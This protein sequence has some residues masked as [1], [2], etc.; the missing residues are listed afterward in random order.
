MLSSVFR[1]KSLQFSLPYLAR[2][3]CILAK[4]NPPC[5]ASVPAHPYQLRSAKLNNGTAMRCDCVRFCADLW[6]KT[7][8]NW[9]RKDCA[10]EQIK[11][12]Q[13]VNKSEII[14]NSRT[15][16]PDYIYISISPIYTYV[17]CVY[18]CAVSWAEFQFHLAIC[19]W[20][21]KRIGAGYRPRLMWHPLALNFGIASYITRDSWLIDT[22]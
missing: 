12:K 22:T 5:F 6:P 9:N 2:V 16:I 13:I 7:R 14:S 8:P 18:M 19:T 11:S 21:Y 15:K 17:Y 20:Q 3:H 10:F 1:P 4:R